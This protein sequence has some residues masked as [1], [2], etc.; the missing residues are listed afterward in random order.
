MN[1]RPCR[2]LGIAAVHAGA[3]VG[4]AW[5]AFACD[6]GGGAAGDADRVGDATDDARGGPDVPA[7]DRGVDAPDLARPDRAVAPEDAVRDASAPTDA[8]P[9][10]PPPPLR[11][12]RE[13][14]LAMVKGDIRLA[15]CIEKVYGE[16]AYSSLG[17]IHTV[18]HELNPRPEPGFLGTFRRVMDCNRPELDCE[19]FL[20][21]VDV[22]ASIQCEGATFSGTGACG[23]D[24]TRI[25]CIVGSTR[26]PVTYCRDTGGT[27]PEGWTGF[28]GCFY[29]ECDP[30][31]QESACGDGIE[32]QC[33]GGH[34]VAARCEREVMCPQ[35]PLTGTNDWDCAR[36]SLSECVRLQEGGGTMVSRCRPAGEAC[37][38]MVPAR[39]L[40][41]HTVRGC[42]WPGLMSTLDCDEFWEGSRC[43]ADTGDPRGAACSFPQDCTQK[44]TCDGDRLRFCL[45]GVVEELD[46]SEM[47]MECRD[48]TLHG[49]EADGCYY[50]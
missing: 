19:E 32:Y 14:M 5:A 43:V 48:A 26:G 18:I 12:N 31:T 25:Q 4:F 15:A 3:L 29:D 30:A 49:F 35:I 50:R 39:C 20:A 42:A 13:N 45:G 33:I 47:G 16:P 8:T 23:A 10:E 46:C 2:Q 27:C 36:Y 34:F 17:S 28:Y 41:D 9:P 11:R 38:G 24:D 40:D 1:A 21:C 6:S 44:Q 22:R 7:V 37:D